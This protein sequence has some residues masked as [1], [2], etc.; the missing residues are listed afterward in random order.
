MNKF[1]G[2][3]HKPSDNFAYKNDQEKEDL[4]DQVRS[5]KLQLEVKLGLIF[6]GGM[7]LFGV[8]YLLY[9]YFTYIP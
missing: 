8:G 6:L 2:P 1:D 5:A 7:L 3:I 4:Q 9:S